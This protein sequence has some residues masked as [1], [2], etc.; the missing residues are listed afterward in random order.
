MITA[1]AVILYKTQKRQDA[2]PSKIFEGQ[3]SVI[4]TPTKFG[5][6]IENR[7]PNGNQCSEIRISKIQDG[8][9]PPSLISILSHNFGVDRHFL[10]QIWY[11]DGKYRQPKGTHCSDIRFSKIQD[12]GQTPSWISKN[13]YNSVVD[14]DICLK[15]CMMV[16][17]ESGK[18]AVC[19]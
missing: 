17:S 1:Y 15:L 2:W 12:N 9:R 14:W 3:Y 6:V 4:M 11:R 18:S 19:I 5:N 7:Q 16:D 13:Y 8:G 10:H